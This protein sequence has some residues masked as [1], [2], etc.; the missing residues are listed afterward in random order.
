M[1]GI[2]YS[3][4][5]D[6]ISFQR[7]VEATTLKEIMEPEAA[8]LICIRKHFVRNSCNFKGHDRKLFLQRSFSPVKPLVPAIFSVPPLNT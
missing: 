2:Q 1:K 8:N 6:F 4:A 3:I 5:V 7:Y